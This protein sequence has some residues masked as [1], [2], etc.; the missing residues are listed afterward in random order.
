MQ[1]PFASLNALANI[2]GL[3]LAGYLN[4]SQAD[5]ALAVGAER[6]RTWQE[7]GSAGEMDYMLRPVQ[8]FADLR[9]IFPPIKSV[10]CFFIPYG[11]PNHTEAESLPM[12]YGRVARYA[13]GRDYHRVLKKKLKKF[14]DLVQAKMSFQIEMKLF[15]DAVPILER[16]LAERALPGFIGKNTMFI[17]PGLGSGGFIAE[18]LWD[19]EV[20]G[21]VELSATVAKGKCGNCSQCQTTCPT[22]ALEHHYKID[23]RRC[24]SYLTIEK[25]G[26]FADW[27]E[28]ALGDWL[29]GCDIC[30]K[31]CPFNHSG[32]EDL[33][34][35]EFGPEMG[36]GPMLSIKDLLL[37]PDKE[38]FLAR[39]AGTAIMRAGWEKMVRN[40]LTVA[41]NQQLL[42]IYP[43]VVE[44]YR[45]GVSDTIRYTAGRTL[46]RILLNMD[47]LER[48]RVAALLN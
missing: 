36:A 42:E 37:I 3:S 29:F 46:Q 12:G 16:A 17:V 8:L 48:R 6:L 41:A 5:S 25:R 47:G 1:I 23:A 34:L 35:S 20:S 24:I 44:L 43:Q 27:E 19:V 22:N 38:K 14:A 10:L 45:Y 7:E 9:N 30:Q 33:G 2:E 18:V 15:T 21:G 31:V 11:N 4:L 32:V 39:F 28:Q 40:A 26:R 13:W